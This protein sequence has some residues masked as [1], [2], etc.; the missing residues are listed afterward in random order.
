MHGEGLY[1]WPDG[2]SYQG[3]YENDEQHGY[4]IYTFPDGRCYKGMWKDGQ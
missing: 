2:R 4:G 3:N 1:K